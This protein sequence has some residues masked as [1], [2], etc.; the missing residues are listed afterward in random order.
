MRVRETVR[1]RRAL[2]RITGHREAGPDLRA[3][4]TLLRDVILGA[5]RQLRCRHHLVLSLRY[6]LFGHEHSVEDTARTLRLST[7]YAR[8]LEVSGLLKLQRCLSSYALRNL[9]H[10]DS[11]HHSRAGLVSAV[12]IGGR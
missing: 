11:Y 5:L 6:G 12:S 2:E 9:D 1:S 4:Q 7:E 3:E 10:W 8:A